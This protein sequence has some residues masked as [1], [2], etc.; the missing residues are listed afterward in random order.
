MLKRPHTYVTGHQAS[1][2]Q[3]S[4]LL[5]T[6]HNAWRCY[7]CCWRRDVIASLSQM[8][9]L[10]SKVRTDNKC[11]WCD[12]G[13]NVIGVTNHLLIGFKSHSTRWNPYWAPLSGQELVARHVTGQRGETTTTVVL[14]GYSSLVTSHYTHRIAHLPNSLHQ[15]IFCLQWMVINTG[16]HNLPRRE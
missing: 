7:S 12:T 11:P 6:F 9:I 2:D 1:T 4:S 5:A 15:R 3:D 14:S 8:W 10:W 13:T 16:T